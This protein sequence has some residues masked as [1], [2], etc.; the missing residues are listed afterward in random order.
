MSEYSLYHSDSD[1]SKFALRSSDKY[2]SEASSG[3]KGSFQ[4]VFPCHSPSVWES[5]AENQADTVE[6]H[7]V[8]THPLAHADLGRLPRDGWNFP[9][10][11]DPPA[12]AVNHG[13]ASMTFP[14]A[15]L[16]KAILQLQFPLQRRC[17]VSCVRLNK[18]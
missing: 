7:N 11:A 6:E 10:R 15:N 4:L 2:Q 14:K 8:V 13:N 9:Q 1:C 16:I 3:G 5:G 18:N 12:A 17:S